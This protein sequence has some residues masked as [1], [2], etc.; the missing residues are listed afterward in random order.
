MLQIDPSERATMSEIFNHVWMRQV[1][2]G[3]FNDLTYSLKIR[4]LSKSPQDPLGYSHSATT[5]VSTSSQG[6]A[7]PLVLDETVSPL[8][9]EKLRIAPSPF[10]IHENVDL[11]TNSEENDREFSPINGPVDH[12]QQSS[13]LVTTARASAKV[14]PYG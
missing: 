6:S 8:T 13:L 4:K 9:V 3:A 7:N 1:P 5:I 12:Q 10:P 14:Y 2:T 11:E